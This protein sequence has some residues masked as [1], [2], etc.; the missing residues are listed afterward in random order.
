[1]KIS[2]K[3]EYGLNAMVELA[4]N[5]RNGALSCKRIAAEQDI[6]LLYLEQIFNKLKKSGLVKAVR[7]PKGGYALSRE[8]AKIRVSDIVDTLQ[9]K[10]FLI[11]HKQSKTKLSHRKA[12]A[13]PAQ[14]FWN[15]LNKGIRSALESTT[16][17]DLCAS[18][19]QAKEIKIEHNY[20]FQ[21]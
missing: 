16:L 15:R 13:N 20:L 12:E 7:G 9:D 19:R 1:M 21:I 11:D 3:T 6:P 17:K 14:L 5:H 4:L 2:K 10:N 8:P 18:P